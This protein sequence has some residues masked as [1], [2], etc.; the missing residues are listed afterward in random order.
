MR[1]IEDMAARKLNPH[2]AAQPHPELRP[3]CRLAQALARYGNARPGTP[4]SAASHRERYQ[5][6]QPQSVMTGVRFLFRITLPRHDLA[7]E[8][9]HLKERQKRL[10]TGEVVRL[11]AG[12]IDSSR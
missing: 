10:R 1:V 6:L 8:V 9:W 12:D 2:N 4:I 5:H 11:R 7:A 3:V